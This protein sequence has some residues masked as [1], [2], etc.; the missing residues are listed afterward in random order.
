MEKVV[1]DEEGHVVEVHCT[2]DPET[3]S[4]QDTSGRKVKGVIHWLSANQAKSANIRVYDRL[5]TVASPDGQESPFTDFINPDS[6]EVFDTALVEPSLA[7]CQPGDS[8]QFERQ[9]YFIADEVLHKPGE[10]LVFNRTVTLRDTWA[11]EQKK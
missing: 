11:K 6:L 5:F 1:K 9:G 4:G 3:R 2:Y 8:F 7:E 10:S